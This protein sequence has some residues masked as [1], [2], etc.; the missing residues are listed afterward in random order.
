M[1]NVDNFEFLFI[2]PAGCFARYGHTD[3]G[4]VS[5]HKLLHLQA[6]PVY[7]TILVMPLFISTQALF[8]YT[9]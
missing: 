9:E 6:S 8:K 7:D 1:I 5:V 4:H 2:Q 3:A